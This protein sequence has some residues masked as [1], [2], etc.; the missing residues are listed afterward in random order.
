MH[1]GMQARVGLQ[2]FPA[3]TLSPS[4]CTHNLQ[5]APPSQQPAIPLT[6]SNSPVSN[7]GYFHVSGSYHFPKPDMGDQHPL[8]PQKGPAEDV[9]SAVNRRSMVCHRNSCANSTQQSSNPSW[10]HPSWSGLE[11]PQTGQEQTAANSMDNRKNNWCPP[12]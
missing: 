3:A 4:P 12:S 10:A 5:E 7:R 8:H 2:R 11:Q 9:L 6:M 1:N